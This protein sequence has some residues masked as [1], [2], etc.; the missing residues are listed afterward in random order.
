MHH[1]RKWHHLRLVLKL[2]ASCTKL[3]LRRNRGTCQEGNT[4]KFFGPFTG[5]AHPQNPK[6]NNATIRRTVS[7]S[8]GKAWVNYPST[9]ST[10]PGERNVREGP[11]VRWTVE[12]LPGVVF[13][14]GE[15]LCDGVDVLGQPFLPEDPFNAVT[16]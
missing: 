15:E 11:L 7:E 4:P 5:T 16:L 9:Q 3:Q 14:G 12:C 2:K 13:A 8:P 6:L 10:G 1:F